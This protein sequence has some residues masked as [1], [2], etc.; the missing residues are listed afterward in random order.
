MNRLK[1]IRKYLKLTQQE[2]ADKLGYKQFK[3]KDIE[4][5][6][7]KIT[8][9]LAD[10]LEKLYSINGWWLLTGKDSMFLDKNEITK[11]KDNNIIINGGN[12]HNGNGDIYIN[13]KDFENGSEIEELVELLKYAPPTLIN[14]ITKK[15][16]G[17]KESC[18]F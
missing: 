1:E 9:E 7:Q 16:K 15:L 11:Q 14:N 4:T 3:I 13:K 8:L 12:N 5:N 6:K 17:F 2:L 18:E 10:K